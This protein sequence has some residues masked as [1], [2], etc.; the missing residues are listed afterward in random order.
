MPSFRQFQECCTN[1][2]CWNW[3]QAP[4][5]L[6]SCTAG[7]RFYEGHFLKVLFDRMGQILDQVRW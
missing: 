4:R 7:S 2:S 5:S 6:E 3:P 1:A